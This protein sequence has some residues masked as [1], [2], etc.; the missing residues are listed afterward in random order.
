MVSSRST[1]A[2]P[3]TVACRIF[4]TVGTDLPFNRLVETVDKWAKERN[5]DDVF[6]QI[7]ETH[8]EPEHIAFSKMLDPQEFRNRFQEAEFVV[9]HAGMGTILTSLRYQKPLL[10][11]PRKASFGEH[12]NEHQLATAR[13]LTEMNKINIAADENV[14]F[15]MLDKLENLPVKEKIGHFASET[16]TR[17]INDFILK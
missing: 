17:T 11:L 10:V 15:N 1:L 6:A 3:K 9:S 7:G 4:V 16:L 12:R 14:L 5:R 13:Y 8:W 2:T